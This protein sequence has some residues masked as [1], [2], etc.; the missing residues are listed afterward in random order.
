M[1]SPWHALE[2]AL[3]GTA[4]EAHA[5]P[6][7]QL[8]ESRWFN[9]PHGDLPRWREALAALPQAQPLLEL[10][11]P[12][13][14]LGASLGD[15]EALTALLMHFHPWRKGPLQLAGVCV[16]SE[17]R[18]DWKWAR[19]EQHLDLE[20][21]VVLDVG[22]GNGYFGWRMLGAG[23]RCVVG[24]DPTLLFVAQ[25]MVQRHFAG[26]G[27]GRAPAN[28]VLPLKDSELPPGLGGFDTVFSMG[29][30]YHRRDPLEHL[31]H[32]RRCLRPGGALVL[33]TLVLE[34][35]GMQV[36]TPP[37]RYAR[38]RN[39]WHI[40]SVD[41]LSRSLEEAGFAGSRLLDLNRTSVDEQRSTRWMRFE[42]LRECLDPQDPRLT[43][44]G[45]PAPL[46]AIMLARRDQ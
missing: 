7:V 8:G 35:D 33:E 31:L 11:R 36:L 15:A 4:L 28:F 45:H 18:S 43:V 30:L 34:A 3:A 20:N 5:R 13:P 24:I 12:A 1:S 17:W 44:E 14:R 2:A 38:M 37:G 16:D 22:C 23:A 32:L 46:R 6:L 41:S 25:W 42:S 19:I 40:P 9:H 21:Q 10:Q 27:Q 29:V 39:V 26:A